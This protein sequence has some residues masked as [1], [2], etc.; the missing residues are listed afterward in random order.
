MTRPW[1][2]FPNVP[3]V[4]RE[5]HN[6]AYVLD[7]RAWNGNQATPNT[8]ARFPSRLEP[9]LGPGLGRGDSSLFGPENPFY[10]C[11]PG[12]SSGNPLTLGN[13]RP[14]LTDDR[15]AL[16]RGILRGVGQT[17]AVAQRGGMRRET[18]R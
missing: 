14:W 16:L 2:S 10:A 5:Q 4:T 12:G 8:S 15:P 18:V 13:V 1:G 6:L 11:F 7:T 3:K 9:S 17:T